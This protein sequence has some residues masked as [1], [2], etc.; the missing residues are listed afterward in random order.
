MI[1]STANPLVKRIRALG[2][3]K[4]RRRESAFFCEGIQPVMRAVE[5]GARIEVLVVSPELVVSPAAADLIADLER[6][7]TRVARL[8]AEVF[9]RISLRDGP[10]GV[11]AIVGGELGGLDS[12]RVTPRSLFVVLHEVANPGNLG[13][14]IRSADAAG[15]AGVVL[16]GTTADP[17]APVAV[18]ASM[19]SL[20]TVPVVR[21]RSADEFFSWAMKNGVT[22]VTTSARGTSSHYDTRF[23]RPGALLFGSEGDGLPP[24]LLKRGQATV[25]IPMVGTVSSLN[26]SVAVGVLLFGA[27]EVEL[28]RSGR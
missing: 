21:E 28:G 27:Q 12:L 8:S 9:R 16:L 25:R 3:A 26:L 13:S 15:A 5:E 10:S 24:D 4:H 19:G 1:T 20:F 14:I 2:D 17:F 18:K 7:G 6:A 11:G 23:L 22:V